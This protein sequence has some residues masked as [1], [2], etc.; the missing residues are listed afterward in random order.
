MTQEERMAEAAITEEENVRSLNT[1]VKYDEER[2]ATQKMLAARR[3]HRGPVIR[4]TSSS[5]LK[6]ANP[7]EAEITNTI[8]FHDL[9]AAE[10]AVPVQERL[11]GISKQQPYPQKP[12]CAISGTTA[13]YKDPNTGIT[14]GDARAYAILK[15]LYKCEI[16]WNPTLQVYVHNANTDIHPDS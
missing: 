5:R 11:L 13:L 4:F 9:T 10:E 6:S 7:D 12:V 14:Y 2:K 1:I 8:S 15:R 3:R 16:R